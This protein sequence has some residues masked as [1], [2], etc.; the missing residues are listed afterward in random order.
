MGKSLYNET[1]V[2]HPADKDSEQTRKWVLLAIWK[3]FL[4]Y[5]LRNNAL[6]ITSVY[7]TIQ[8]Q[9]VVADVSKTM[10]QP[11]FMVGICGYYSSSLPPALSPY[12][13]IDKIDSL[14]RNNKGHF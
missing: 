1:N 7:M 6:Y 13:V 12:K 8:P 14:S 10:S 11:G 4:A 3:G 5:L 9:M 2:R